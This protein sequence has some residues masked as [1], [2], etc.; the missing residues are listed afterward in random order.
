MEHFRI[1]KLELLQ[2]LG[3]SIRNSG[4]LIQYTVDVS[5]YLLISHCKDTFTHTNRQKSGF[6]QQIVV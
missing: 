1:P 3:R 2:S 4:A 6:T 5:E